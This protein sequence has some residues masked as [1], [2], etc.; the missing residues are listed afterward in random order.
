MET[1]AGFDVPHQP[2]V[3]WYLKTCLSGWE[4]KGGLALCKR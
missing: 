3:H 1:C 2:A 4:S